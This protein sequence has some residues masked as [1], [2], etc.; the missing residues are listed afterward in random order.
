MAF[1]KL[2]SA[3]FGLFCFSGSVNPVDKKTFKNKNTDRIRYMREIGTKN[4]DSV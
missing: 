4:S 1:L 2:L 3:K